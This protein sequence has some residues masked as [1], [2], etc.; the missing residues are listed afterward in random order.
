ML[1]VIVIV[2]DTFSVFFHSYH[3]VS[4]LPAASSYFQQNYLKNQLYITCPAPNGR[5]IQLAFMVNIMEH[6]S[7]YRANYYLQGFLETKTDLNRKGIL[8]L[9]LP[10][11]K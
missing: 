11:G 3:S 5:R 1:V 8:D 4:F 6:F 9:H 10:G 2:T 7:N